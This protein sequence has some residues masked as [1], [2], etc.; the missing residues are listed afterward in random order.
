[1]EFDAKLSGDGQIVLFHDETL[2]RTTNG[3]GRVADMSLKDLRALDAGAWF[4]EPFRGERIPTLSEALVALGELGLG[5]NVEIKP[6]PGREE[7][8]AEAVARTLRREWP[9][10]LPPPIISSFKTESL[11][12]ASALL[13]DCPHAL[14]V[15]DVP[16]DWRDCL[17]ALACTALHCTGE[18]LTRELAREIRAA[19]YALRCYTIN[20]VD[21]ARKLF[22]WGVEAVFS[23]YPDRI[24]R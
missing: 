17:A 14:I 6:D 9:R 11:L 5:A 22:D 4:G 19:G 12:A 13:S 20:D 21:T 24:L 2:E 23:D 18:G 16:D 3:A 15:D 7:E 10:N 8:T 1:V